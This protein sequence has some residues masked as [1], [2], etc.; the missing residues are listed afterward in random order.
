MGMEVVVVHYHRGG[1][2]ALGIGHLAFKSLSYTD[3]KAAQQGFVSREK[4]A[5]TNK[6]EPRGLE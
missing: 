6:L 4:R 5:R 1:H 2:W 3:S